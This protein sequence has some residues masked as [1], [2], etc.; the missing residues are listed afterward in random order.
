MRIE[1]LQI[2]T[3]I[4]FGKLLSVVRR[5]ETAKHSM[6]ES[7]NKKIAIADILSFSV[8]ADTINLVVSNLHG[9]MGISGTIKNTRFIIKTTAAAI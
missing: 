2:K 4:H 8:F 1:I 9:V 7:N 5:I 3:F 6:I